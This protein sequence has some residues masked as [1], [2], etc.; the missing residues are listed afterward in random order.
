MYK[1]IA[2]RLMALFLSICM[3][4]GMIDLTSFTV[5]AAGLSFEDDGTNWFFEYP[6]IVTYTGGALEPKVTIYPVT[7]GVNGTPLTEGTHYNVTYSNNTNFGTGTITIEGI[8]DYAGSLV[9]ETFQIQRKNLSGNATLASI[10]TQKYHGVPVVPQITVTDTDRKVELQGTYSTSAVA[11]Y[12][13]YYSI[14]NN[15]G[16]GT[17]TIQVTGCG[18][19][20]GA[21]TG[22]FEIVA[23]EEALLNIDIKPSAPYW[24]GSEIEPTVTVTYD[25]TPLVEGTDYNKQFANN[26]KAGT[27]ATVIITG[28]NDYAGLEKTATFTILKRFNRDPINVD[29]I[30][31]QPYTGQQVTLKPE[32]IKVYDP[33]Y[34]APL[35]PVDENGEGDYEISGHGANINKGEG[36][37]TVTIRG[38]GAYSGTKTITFDIVSADMSNVD[39][40]VDDTDCIYDGTG[41]VPKVT[42]SSGTVIY[43]INKDYTIKTSND[44]NAGT[45][46]AILTVS[47]VL[48]GKLDG[49][50]RTLNYTIHPR[51]LSDPE[52][53]ME[54]VNYI[55]E[56]YN[57]SEV[58]P[59]V[60]LAYKGSTLSTPSNYTIGYTNNTNAG[61]ATVTATGAGNFTGTKSLTFTIEAAS[62]DNAVISDVPDQTYSGSPIEMN[63]TITVNGRRLNRYNAATQ[64]GDYEL[65]YVN[66]TN[67]GTATITITGKNNYKGTK[68]KEFKILPRELTA[69]MIVNIAPQV[70]TGN[71]IE[72]ELTIKYN[73]KDL[74]KDTDYTVSYGGEDTNKNVGTNTAVVRVE[75][76]PGG[77]FTTSKPVEKNFSIT[78]RNLA[79]GDYLHATNLEESYVHTGSPI[80]EAGLTIEYI[81]IDEGMNQTLA[82]NKDYTLKYKDNIEIGIASIEVTGNGNY[83]GTKTFTFRI[84]GSL[85]NE[86]MTKVTIPPQVYTGHPVTA[87]GHENE[88]ENMTVT[89]NGKALTEG[90]DFTVTY[91]NNTEVGELS[92]QAVITGQ[93]DYQDSTGVIYFTIK[94]KNLDTVT[95]DSKDFIINGIPADGFVYSGYKIDPQIEV[96]Y[97]DITLIKDTDYT[98]EYGDN[99]EVGEGSITLKGLDPHFEGTHVRKFTIHPYDIEAGE[100][101]SKLEIRGL[102]S[103]VILDNID[104]TNGVTLDG[105]KVVQTD[106]SV[107]YTPVNVIDGSEGTARELNLT[108]EYTISYEANDK[109]GVAKVIFEGKGNFGGKIEKPFAIKGDLANEEST[110]I[111][112]IPDYPYTPSATSEPANRP[113][114]EVTYRGEKLE[115]ET[116]YTVS[117]ENN[118]NVG[119]TATVKVTANPDGNYVN[120]ATKTF[121]I[122][123]RVLSQE[124]PDITIEGLDPDGYEYTGEEITPELTIQCKGVALVEGRDYT[125]TAENNIEVPELEVGDGVPV[126]PTVIIAAID[127]SNYKGEIRLPFTI[128]PRQINENTIRVDNVEEEYDYDNGNP[129]VVPDDPDNPDDGVIVTYIKDGKEERLIKD[130]DYTLEYIDN[131]QI[132]EATIKITGIN[133]YEGT[134]DKTFR[135]MANLED[136]LRDGYI[137]LDYEEEVGYGIIAVYPELI[138]TDLTAEEPKILGEEDFE[139]VPEKCQNNIHVANKDSENPPTMV[140]RGIGCYRGEVTITYTIVPK[141]LSTDEEDITA[142]FAGSINNET[143]TNAYEYTGSPIE[144]TITVFNHGQQMGKDTDYIISGYVNNTNVPPKDA[145]D[146][147]RPGVIITAVENGN[148]VGSKVMYFDI[149]PRSIS[150]MKIDIIDGTQT[151]NRK[152]KRPAIELY[153]MAGGER[154]VVPTNNYDIEYTN[155]IVAATNRDQNAP[156]IKITGKGN[157]G[158]ELTQT[159]TIEPEDIASDDIIIT[160]SGAI[161]TGEPVTTTFKIK[162][163]DGTELVEGTDYTIG[164]YSDNT[165]V[166]TGYAEISGI[167]NY[168][169][170]CKAEFS[171][172]PAEGDFVIENIPDQVYNTKAISPKLNV[173]LNIDGGKLSIPLTEGQHYK[174]T[175]SNNINAGTASVKIVGINNF[176][177][178]KTA[179]FKIVK[180]SIGTS[181]G[182]D[183]NMVLGAIAN[184]QYNGKGIIP[185]VELAFRNPAEQINSQLVVGKDYR[186]SCTNNVAVGTATATI[187]GINNYTGT[188]KTTFKILGNMNLATVTKIPVQDYT[189]KPVTP[190][191]QVSFA[192]KKLKEGAGNDYTLEYKNNIERGTASIIITGTGTWYTGRKTVTFDIAREF[193]KATSV[194]GVA[195]AYVYTGSAIKPSVRVEDNGTVLTKGTDYKVTYSKNTNVGTAT[196]T[197][198]GI[199]K[200]RG[201]KKVTFKITPQQLGRASITNLK[202]LDYSGKAK[203]PKLKVVVGNKTLKLDRDY[204]AVYVNNKKPGKAS[205]IIKGKGNYTGTKKDNFNIVIPKVTNV[206]VS[207]YT[208][209]SATISWKK[210]SAVT[211]YEIYNSRNERLVRATKASTIKATVNKLK[212][213]TTSTFKVRAYVRSGGQYY[214]GPFVKINATTGPK[215]TKITSLTSKKSKQV[216]I[217]WSSIKGANK[218][219]IYRSTSAR[220]KFKK[221]GTSKKT[222]YTDKKAT[223]GKKYYYKIR[224]WKK[225]GKKNY[226]SDYSTVQSIKAKK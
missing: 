65:S 78:A 9:T 216:A 176:K 171:I 92:A 14:A 155:N 146:D 52:V 76:M 40:N 152:E 77:N 121:K 102:V 13:Y 188:I 96:V 217:K 28:I 83:S 114:P 128:K 24:S 80:T 196:I 162:A 144:P 123:H 51:P 167:G 58:R 220:G 4:A 41:K 82:L 55:P 88:E 168:T 47:P 64:E 147:Q 191:P 214:Y 173:T 87:T 158:G 18:N 50:P 46:T 194:R 7:D 184:Q 218:Y 154:T 206:K 119:D 43:E 60:K 31:P 100:S 106:L 61:V 170:T 115:A 138:F 202:N 86:S 207:K 34:D 37:G 226:Y 211:G 151:F 129:I 145:E 193:S 94:K 111:A 108:D 84:K 48:G 174:A 44:A 165:M 197:V 35:R 27:G 204:T 98:L 163:K 33:D 89:Y 198:T 182:I 192:G 95:E 120:E 109:I 110:K 107:W 10:D 178:E 126:L 29:P 190:V 53:T 16:P 1:E 195:S 219:D 131:V 8:G 73:G 139:L 68:T 38:L 185:K 127:G 75:A 32:Q 66:N 21:L 22:S 212:S 172:L 221:I 85:A 105:D 54:L 69:G 91:T 17:A 2:R 104:T 57:G 143:Y 103:E 200:Y 180:K 175:Y 49:Q 199:N 130:Q 70:Y 124:D 30:D 187:T 56:V 134:L 12:D 222:S 203:T 122:V 15:N 133:N 20:T 101:N 63:V 140:I 39:I 59:N 79:T 42:V 150:N 99:T 97:H 157:Y 67:V 209:T 36:A 142:S 62:L 189:G 166:G 153:Y 177:G 225:I 19:Y 113:E 3:I 26:V 116:D 215:A 132:G 223:N 141:D 125:I 23:L 93:G 179:Q 169:G 224:V 6:D 117:Y 148:Y 201:T 90:K 186:V 205:V 181:A 136:G 213:A 74:I 81:K 45:N 149:I 11:G 137:T 135:I 25:G 5:R 159:F 164:K 112:D 118:E 208:S 210:N 156:T 161:Y 72:P 160:S 71:V 183:A